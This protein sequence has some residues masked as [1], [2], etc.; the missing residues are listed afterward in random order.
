MANY[1]ANLYTEKAN[2][3][4]LSDTG[5]QVTKGGNMD[6]EQFISEH[7]NE[8]IAMTFVH[9]GL[10]S[11]FA[12]RKGRDPILFFFLGGLFG[13][14]PLFYL[15]FAKKKQVPVLATG[16]EAPAESPLPRRGWYYLA[17]D[18]TQIGP[19]SLQDLLTAWD[20]K[21][22]SSSTYV[23]NERMND[24]SQIAHVPALLSTFR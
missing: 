24:W 12:F 11:F 22:I 18:E 13:L 7:F 6:P 19:V 3:F 17:K 4:P 15:A 10:S 5:V 21:E 1:S 9:A 23:W 8:L 14:L 20:R 16:P 2:T